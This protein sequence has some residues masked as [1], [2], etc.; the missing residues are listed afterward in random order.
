MIDIST[1]E[2]WINAK[3]NEILKG[4]VSDVISEWNEQV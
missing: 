4:F 1:L 3:K 2:D